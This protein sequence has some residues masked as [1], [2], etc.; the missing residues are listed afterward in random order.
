MSFKANDVDRDKSSDDELPS[1]QKLLSPTTTP[2]GNPSRSHSLNPSVQTARSPTSTPLGLTSTPRRRLF[3]N[4]PEWSLFQ[5]P[6]AQASTPK[7]QTEA[8]NENSQGK[9]MILDSA[10]AAN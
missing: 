9:P 1:L 4:V 7:N 10:L 8:N 6:P 2:S 3:K 5:Y